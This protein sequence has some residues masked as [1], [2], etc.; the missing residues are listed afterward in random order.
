MTLAVA[1]TVAAVG[2][3]TNAAVSMPP[4]NN[5]PP[6]PPTF[7]EQDVVRQSLLHVQRCSSINEATDAHARLLL[8]Y[9][10]QIYNECPSAVVTVS[11][12]P[13]M[14]Q[15]PGGVRPAASLLTILL[16]LKGRAIASCDR[17][18]RAAQALRVGQQDRDLHRVHGRAPHEGHERVQPADSGHAVRCRSQV[19]MG[20]RQG[21]DAEKLSAHG[22]ELSAAQTGERRRRGAQENRCRAARCIRSALPRRLGRPICAHPPHNSA[23]CHHGG[24]CHH[25]RV[26]A[27]TSAPCIAPA[28]IAA[29]GA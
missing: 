19:C 14:Q 22:D 11:V 20:L 29:G 21:P 18:P 3:P 24:L 28:R 8:N 13:V 9:W 12:L 17:C 2:K 23:R 26:P 27:L 10:E 5:M 15:Q 6:C 16:R 1:A 25:R 7:R 4:S